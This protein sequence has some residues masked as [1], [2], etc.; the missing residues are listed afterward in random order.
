MTR[1]F[2]RSK[3][4]WLRSVAL[5]IYYVPLLGYYLLL[6][7]LLLLRSG[8]NSSIKFN[9]MWVACAAGFPHFPMSVRSKRETGQLATSSL[10]S[11][12]TAKCMSTRSSF[13]NHNFHKLEVSVIAFVKVSSPFKGT[14]ECWNF[15]WRVWC[16]VFLDVSVS[17][18]YVCESQMPCQ[19]LAFIWTFLFE[20]IMDQVVTIHHSPLPTSTPTASSERVI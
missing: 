17:C 12:T 8:P 6:L 13:S 15:M 7:L 2:T 18:V 10:E 9:C 3:P 19:D 5:G 11:E 16:F 14:F 20:R 4:L 1:A